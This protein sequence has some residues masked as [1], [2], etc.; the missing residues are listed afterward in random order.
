MPAHIS[1]SNVAQQW[2]KAIAAPTLVVRVNPG[3]VRQ[4]PQVDISQSYS[5]SSA[6]LISERWDEF[7]RVGFICAPQR[8]HGSPLGRC[9]QLCANA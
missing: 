5:I 9:F 6:R 1:I 8:L 2:H 4:A 7:A 3:R